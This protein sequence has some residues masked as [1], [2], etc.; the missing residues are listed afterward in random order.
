[1]QSL[2]RQTFSSAEFLVASLLLRAFL[3]AMIEC[4]TELGL[5]DEERQEVQQVLDAN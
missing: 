1:M 2:P 3:C 4:A 5:A